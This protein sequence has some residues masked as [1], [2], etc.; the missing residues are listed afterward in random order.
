MAQRLGTPALLGQ[1]HVVRAYIVSKFTITSHVIMSILVYISLL[2]VTFLGQEIP[3]CEMLIHVA[4]L[5][6]RKIVSIY[7]FH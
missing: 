2:E 5:S 3:I 6:S 7:T 1:F 4:I